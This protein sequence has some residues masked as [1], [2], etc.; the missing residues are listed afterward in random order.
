MPWAGDSAGNDYDD[1]ESETDTTPSGD[2]GDY[3]GGGGPPDDP[4]PT[5]GTDSDSSTGDM[6]GPGGL[7]D[8]PQL[9]DP[10]REEASGGDTGG[11]TGGTTP[12]DPDDDPPSNG[13]GGGGST[14]TGTSG[15]TSSPTGGSGGQGRQ[16]SKSDST[17]NTDPSLGGGLENKF[18]AQTGKENPTADTVQQLQGYI[19]RNVPG[20]NVTDTQKYNITREGNTLSVTFASPTKENIQRR[21][22]DNATEDGPVTGRTEAPDPSTVEDPTEVYGVVATNTDQGASVAPAIRQRRREKT[23]EQE[24]KETVRKEIANDVSGAVPSDVTATIKESGGVTGTI[25]DSAEQTILERRRQLG[26]SA[27]PVASGRVTVADATAVDGD[28][29]EAAADQAASGLLIRAAPD[30]P[31]AEEVLS[32]NPGQPSGSAFSRRTP[33]RRTVEQALAGRQPQ[34]RD[35]DGQVAEGG[36]LETGGGE[37]FDPRTANPLAPGNLTRA[38]LRSRVE[39]SS[40]VPVAYSDQESGPLRR[41]EWE[42]TGV[43]TV[44]RYGDNDRLNEPGDFDYDGALMPRGSGDPT[45]DYI[46]ALGKRPGSRLDT[47][48]YI[49]RDGIDE[50]GDLDRLG[51]PGP[52]APAGSG[53]PATDLDPLDPANPQDASESPEIEPFGGRDPD[54]ST[55]REVVGALTETGGSEDLNTDAQAQ[56]VIA[57][58]LNRR[59][60]P[61]ASVSPQGS[62][63]GPQDLNPVNPRQTD[64]PSFSDER[65]ERLSQQQA[66]TPATQDGESTPESPAESATPT[67]PVAA[68]PTSTRPRKPRSA[69][70]TDKFDGVVAMADRAAGPADELVGKYTRG[71]TRDQEIVKSATRGGLLGEGRT[72]TTTVESSGLSIPQGARDAKDVLAANPSLERDDVEATKERLRIAADAEDIKES[73]ARQRTGVQA[74]DVSFRRRRGEVKPVVERETGAK[75]G[76]LRGSLITELTGLSEEDLADASEKYQGYV[77]P[78][79]ESINGQGDARDN[80][81]ENTVEGTVNFFAQMGDVPQAVQG[82]EALAEAGDRKTRAKI[83]L[84]PA[85]AGDT[86]L[87]TARDKGEQSVN[88]A[89]KNPGTIAGAGVGTALTAGAGAVARGGTLTGSLSSISARGLA[90]RAVDEV[91]P[92]KGFGADLVRKGFR[93]ARRFAGDDRG[94]ADLTG[95]GRRRDGDSGSSTLGS[96][97]TQ[98]EES[99]GT[100]LPGDAGK[101]SRLGPEFDRE[102]DV[103]AGGPI[104]RR[105]ELTRRESTPGQTTTGTL[106][107][108]ERPT[109]SAVTRES[110][111]PGQRGDDSDRQVSD[112]LGRKERAEQPSVG[113]DSD[114]RLGGRE[115]GLAGGLGVGVGATAGLVG[116][117]LGRKERAEQTSFGVESSVL[118]SG[119]R[120][121]VDTRQDT[122]VDTG[123]RSDAA[124]DLGMDTDQG[125][126][127][128]TDTSVDTRTDLG[129]DQGT[130]TQLDR[131]LDFGTDTGRDRKRDRGIDT[132]DPRDRDPD[133]DLDLKSG[134]ND[135]LLGQKVDEGRFKFETPSLL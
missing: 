67:G 44:R 23:L 78:K 32:G 10:Q 46:R 82:T 114:G 84:N 43:S 102:S 106:G 75:P 80:L 29:A 135:A 109:R 28:A 105:R 61:A 63:L 13:S 7:G 71:A 30:R 131:G 115:K 112:A 68:L 124:L 19:G 56:N 2:R 133:L 12:P 86:A 5:G 101:M 110:G 16:S 9:D 11:T 66:S 83:V 8:D 107:L 108:D 51:G 24:V 69:R 88:F 111:L 57:A 4:D 93:S 121:G 60:S 40:G 97:L 100:G 92:T 31:T 54:A 15:G 21:R 1:Y 49:D 35:G 38:Q 117:A 123:A 20:V 52:A 90:K 132:G 120:T 70:R 65:A 91:D 53:A 81:A 22:I 119:G 79:I 98:L 134:G 87:A 104:Q 18:G 50:P 76:L 74:S 41:L 48:A 45:E 34:Q 47:S 116:G 27:D 3:S 62:A 77:R 73:I 26:D 42:G 129:M 127:V 64:Q 118:G 89:R 37:D 33:P 95:P 58:R 94:Q 72:T 113:R 25:S 6:A 96:S 55:D 59:L 17:K 14:D 36:V 99:G 126:D 85:A 122:G 128:G 125:L 39:P 103:D 130:D